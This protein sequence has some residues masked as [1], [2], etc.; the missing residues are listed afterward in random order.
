VS[1]APAP[2]QLL[3]DARSTSRVG[4][5]DLGANAARLTDYLGAVEDQL[6]TGASEAR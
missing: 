3:V 2:G 1:R 6:M 4:L 5:G